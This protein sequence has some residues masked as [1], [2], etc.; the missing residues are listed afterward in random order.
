MRF[1]DF[2][3]E[4]INIPV[5]SRP[6]TI[7]K[8]TGKAIPGGLFD[9]DIFG[10]QGSSKYR[11]SYGAIFL[12]CYIFSPFFCNIIR[13]T[14]RKLYR[15]I[16]ENLRFNI[17]DDGS[18]EISDNGKY[19]GI[20][21]AMRLIRQNKL[22]IGKSTN[23][24]R[25]ELV[26]ILQK[27]P[28]IF[29]NR[30]LVPPPANRPISYAD[31]IYSVHESNSFLTDIISM[32]NQ[33]K[34]ITINDGNI[35][36]HS[37][38]LSKIQSKLEEYV[39]FIRET[40]AGKMGNMRQNLISK[41]TDFSGRTVIV[42]DSTLRMDE[43]SIPFVMALTMFKP[44][45][46]HYMYKEIDKIRPILA[47][48]YSDNVTSA[49]MLADNLIDDISNGRLTHPDIVKFIEP[50]LQSAIKSKL[51]VMKRDPALHRDSIRSF[52]VKYNFS[53]T[54][55]INHL[56]LTPFNADFDGD[57]MA[58]ILPIT[59]QAQEAAKKLLFTSNIFSGAKSF[60][61]AIQMKND[62]ILGLYLLTLDD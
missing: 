54:T 37:D 36:Q 10:E 24:F 11:T 8:A 49:H 31:G 1:I 58:V 35:L 23:N 28:A 38:R 2:D 25:K 44:F 9:R 13:T 39:L 3:K 30:I 45:I 56:V 12:N 41:T 18:I 42:N 57:T 46:L 5:V 52:Y 60:R 14:N 15:V 19:I 51:I 20:Y 62:G 47:K 17:L 53:M 55:K 6:V 16:M 40:F 48:I 32:S 50:Y 22:I 29:I 4:Y 26:E 7:D 34:G 59:Q 21:H 27:S 43:A 61:P 33:L